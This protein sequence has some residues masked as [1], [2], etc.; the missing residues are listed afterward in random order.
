MTK[1]Y[2]PRWQLAA[3]HGSRSMSAP[4]AFRVWKTGTDAHTP[5]SQQVLTW[6]LFWPLLTLIARQPVYFAGP[7]RT[8][9]GYQTGAA[10]SGARGSHDYLYVNM[11]FLL[12]FVLAGHL[13]VWSVVKKNLLIFAML[14]LA[15]CS[16]L[17]SG[18]PR[19]TLQM[20]VEVG[21]CTLFGCYL[22]ARFTTER[23]MQLLIFMGV[24]A[25]LLSI[26]F[27]CRPPVVWHFSRIRRG[28]LAGYLQAQE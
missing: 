8:A 17:W 13:Q 3:V 24:I 28:G 22:S 2:N 19:I 4:S 14:A 9:V 11:L 1:L 7:A 5:V 25:A 26:F 18:S 16:A 10:M 27:A 23:F 6:L 15:V 21:L 20:C 12:G